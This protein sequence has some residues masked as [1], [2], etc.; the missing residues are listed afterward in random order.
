LFIHPLEASGPE[1][2]ILSHQPVEQKVA[3]I[4]ITA[5]RDAKLLLK[6][7]E[8]HIYFLPSP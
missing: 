7:L 2:S 1:L 6:E 3:L 8:D 5:T 4:V